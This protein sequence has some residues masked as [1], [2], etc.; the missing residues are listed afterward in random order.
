[1][2]KLLFLLSILFG[3]NAQSQILID[4]TAPYNSTAHLLNNVLIGGGIV[5]SNPSFIGAPD[6]IGFFNSINSNV[7]IDSGIVLS[8]GEISDIIGP[9]NSNGS[10]GTSFYF[11]A[12]GDGDL[13]LDSIIF[14]DETNDA[15]V[16]EFDFI[17]NSGTLSFRYVFGSEEYLE[18]VAN[19]NDVFGF[20]L[21]GPNPTGGNYVDEN[22]AIITGT[23]NTPV[24]IN[25]V[26]DANNS[27]Y[28]INNGTGSAFN[29]GSQYTDATV[30]QFD[31]FTTP[32]TAFANVNCGDTYHIKLV[33]ADAVD[34]SYD[35]GIFLEAGSFLSPEVTVNNTLGID[36]NILAITCNTTVDLTASSIVGS[37]F[38]WFDNNSNFIS[39]NA[40][41]SAGPGIYVVSAT[42]NGCS[43]L[44][45]TI[46]VLFEMPAA[47]TGLACYETAN[48]DTPTCSWIVT[49]TQDPIPTVDCWE[50]ANFDTPTCSWIVTGTQDPIPT[51][52]DCWENAN[53]D[54]STCDWDIESN[55]IFLNFTATSPI[56]RYDKSILSIN[57]S[58]STSN[59]YTVLLQDSILKSFVIDTNGLLTLTG[60]PVT[61]S[62]NFSGK[63]NIV[64]LTDSE[65]C[66]QIFNDDVHI[67][68]KQ[69]PILSINE[70]DICEESPSFTLNSATPS[71]GFYSINS[72]LTDYF[73]VE[74]LGAGMHNIGYTYTDPISSCSNQINEI[75][76]I[77]ESP[78]AGMLFSPQPS[79]IDNPNIFFRDNSNE[80]VLHSEWD[81]GD[82]TIINDEPSFWHTYTDTGTYTI[83]YYITNM[84]QCTDSVVKDLTINPIYSTFIPDAFT[85]NND[86][87][88]DYFFPSI[89]G[90]NSY[91]MK[92]YN[93]WG[94]IIYN[95]DNGIWDG[96]INN[97]VVQI[98]FYS[99][100]IL[101]NDFKDKPFVYTGIVNLAK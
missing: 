45:D 101:V 76:N 88:N 40:T 13:T 4:N 19:F 92:I 11:S 68:V 14:P 59:I 30:I 72:E 90:G 21:S 55:E 52:L 95:E 17:P 97:N 25:N 47:P 50:N 29:G 60:L 82:G 93:R 51:G 34:H 64:S 62:P 27:A 7:G 71:G 85:P 41:I 66:T 35:S 12:Y 81:L 6:Q 56:C 22:I 70:E 79:N 36:T 39:S 9:N 75:I 44:G 89:I 3:I 67:E 23:V 28:Y 77:N 33:V 87:D 61:L 31:G 18:Y 32:L 74:S 94:A 80:V 91:N 43:V 49:G 24:S 63:V 38:E 8:T 58:N 65:G 86:G 42:I 100:S 48:F 2:R 69:L 26:N 46:Q 96:K 99:Y 1:M 20:F 98:G 83:K 15:A 16:L 57:I 53:F 37:T 73:D 54:T 10:F 84:Y 78:K 5:I